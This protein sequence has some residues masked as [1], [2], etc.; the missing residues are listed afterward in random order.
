MSDTPVYDMMAREC[1]FEREQ[2]G[3]GLCPYS[4]SPLEPRA[5]DDGPRDPG[6]DV[7][8]CGLCDCFGFDRSDPRI[9]NV[10]TRPEVQ[11]YWAPVDAFEDPNAPTLAE[12]EAMNPLGGIKFTFEEPF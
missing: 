6:G 11:V 4:G 9:A 3:R 2:L 8:S 10:K 5:Y 12:L 1:A 7:M